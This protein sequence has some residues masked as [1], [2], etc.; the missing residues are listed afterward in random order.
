MGTSKNT[1]QWYIPV[2]NVLNACF[3]EPAKIKEA[4]FY[5]LFAAAMCNPARDNYKHPPRPKSETG[6]KTEHRSPLQIWNEQIALLRACARAVEQADISGDTIKRR[7]LSMQDVLLK[8]DAL[9]LTCEQEFAGKNENYDPDLYLSFFLRPMQQLCEYTVEAAFQEVLAFYTCILTK[10][11][12]TQPN[13]L[14][15]ALER[16]KG[17]LAHMDLDCT[18]PEC[19]SVQKEAAWHLIALLILYASN[20]HPDI[21]CKELKI[22]LLGIIPPEESATRSIPTLT[23]ITLSADQ[24]YTLCAA[25]LRTDLSLD[26]LRTVYKLLEQIRTLGDGQLENKSLE[27]ITAFFDVL[28]TFYAAKDAAKDRDWLDPDYLKDRDEAKVAQYLALECKKWIT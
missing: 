26:E 28:K 5:R 16:M 17:L 9:Q 10:I 4:N 23:N 18:I 24:F 15:M 27:L 12:E 1:K 11:F 8:T 22:S 25:A 6:A 14:D 7:V 2:L 21:D 19:T 20:S 3:D 13:V